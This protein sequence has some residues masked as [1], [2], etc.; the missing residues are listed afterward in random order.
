[1]A[2]QIAGRVIGCAVKIHLCSL[3]EVIELQMERCRG[4][5]LVIIVCAEVLAS[6]VPSPR[7]PTE[8]CMLHA[9]EVVGSTVVATKNRA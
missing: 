8:Q 3:V 5:C 2:D 7:D 4:K 9:L 6:Q 1:M